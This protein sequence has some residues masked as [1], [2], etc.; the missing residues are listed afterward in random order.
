M[1]GTHTS[2]EAINEENSTDLSYLPGKSHR[3]SV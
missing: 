1:M 3:A 2:I